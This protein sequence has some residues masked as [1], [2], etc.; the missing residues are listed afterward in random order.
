M[1]SSQC[2]VFVSDQYELNRT[3]STIF[4]TFYYFFLSFSSL[5]AFPI[6][7][8]TPNA[9]VIPKLVLCRYPF[10]LSRWSVSLLQQSLGLAKC[11]LFA[12]FLLSIMSLTCFLSSLWQIWCIRVYNIFCLFCLSA[13]AYVLTY[14]NETCIFIKVLS[15]L[16]FPKRGLKVDEWPHGDTK[17]PPVWSEVI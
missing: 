14:I 13:G 2:T 8:L 17:Q 10:P 15:S 6:P 4:K 16:A 1:H 12:I 3:V 7:G 9:Y 5:S 11:V